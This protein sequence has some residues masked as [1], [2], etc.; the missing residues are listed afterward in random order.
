MENLVFTQLS[1]PEVKQ[2]FKQELENFFA[3]N[4][5]QSEAS[6]SPEQLLTINETANFLHLAVP[7]I[8]GMV[9]KREIPF[10]KKRGR[11]YFLKSEL[12]DW[13]K[14]GRKKT[15]IEAEKGAG[16]HLVKKEG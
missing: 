10:N 7:T 6:E 14:E 4:P 2:L 3:V 1:I 11:L 9:S 15:L 5:H 12:I 16:K 13:I 8:Y